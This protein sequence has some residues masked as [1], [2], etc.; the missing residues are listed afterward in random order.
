MAD[1]VR[2]STSTTPNP[3]TEYRQ[4]VNTPDYDGQ[5]NVLINPNLSAVAGQPLRYW[6]HVAGAIQ[7]MTLAEQ[8]AV[9]AAIAAALLA[10]QRNG[11]KDIFDS[12]VS[13]GKI[14]KAVVLLLID[15]LNTLRTFT[16]DFKTETAAATN[17]ANFQTRIATL[18]TLADRT[19]AQART[20]IRTKI[21][22]GDAD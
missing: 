15:E 14:L 16:R 8:N 3:I 13:D 18:P 6:K 22:N 9:D 11:A 17:L 21:D 12:A 4:S 5:P 19:A 7:L 10:S 20:A 2:Y 1:I